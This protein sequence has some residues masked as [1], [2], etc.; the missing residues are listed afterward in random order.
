[1]NQNYE[2]Q[3]EEKKE[4]SYQ[5]DNALAKDHIKQIPENLEEEKKD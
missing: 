2:D 4:G 5:Q 3:E 1:M